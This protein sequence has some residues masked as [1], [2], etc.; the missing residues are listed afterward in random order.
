RCVDL[1]PNKDGAWKLCNIGDLQDREKTLAVHVHETGLMENRV[2]AHQRKKAPSFACF[3]AD[4]P[5]RSLPAVSHGSACHSQCAL[6]T[7]AITQAKLTR[8]C[9]ANGSLII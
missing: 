2:T 1:R 3:L 9:R 7:I 6:L 5:N 4:H 8:T